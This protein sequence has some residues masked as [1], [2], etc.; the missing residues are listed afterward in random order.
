MVLHVNQKSM[1]TF[2][3]WSYTTTYIRILCHDICLIQFDI[4]IYTSN[5]SICHY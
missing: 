2:Q 4:Y 3:T 1:P 5:N